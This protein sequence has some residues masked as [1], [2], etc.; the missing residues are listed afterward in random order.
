MRF[1]ARTI[2]LLAAEFAEAVASGDNA[3]A[4]GWLA[5]AIWASERQPASGR[6]RLWARSFPSLGRVGRR[7]SATTQ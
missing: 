4:E 2:D 1:R 6:I 5:T 3:G 7:V